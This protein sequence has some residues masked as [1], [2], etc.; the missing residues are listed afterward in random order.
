MQIRG[1]AD[2]GGLEVQIEILPVAGLGFVDLVEQA[3]AV[4]VPDGLLPP[5]PGAAV[6]VAVGEGVDA[7]DAAPV[8][9]EAE[10][11]GTQVVFALPVGLAEDCVWRFKFPRLSFLAPHSWGFPPLGLACNAAVAPFTSRGYGI[12]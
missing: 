10:L 8:G 4:V 5:A 11:G 7:L 2:A 6:E 12:G 1:R 3:D 9:E